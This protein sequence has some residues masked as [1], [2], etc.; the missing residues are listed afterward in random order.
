MPQRSQERTKLA[1]A[2]EQLARAR[3][4]LARAK[5]AFTRLS[6]HGPDSVDRQKEL[7]ERALAATKERAPRMMVEQ[8]LGTATA[9]A[10]LSVEAAEETLRVATQAAEAA[11]RARALLEEEQRV[12]EVSIEEAI[13]RRDMALSAVVQSSAEIAAACDRFRAAQQNFWDM[14]WLLSSIGVHRL[15][16]A[17]RS[18]DGVRHGVDRG[19]G[20]PWR[21]AITALEVDPD[22]ALPGE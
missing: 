17:F 11:A 2:I 9:E 20:K 1:E 4:R 12:A 3:D 5:K 13:V 6:L 14:T 7:A 8:L 18:W 21:A 15:P 19:A 10:E 22:A 16:Q